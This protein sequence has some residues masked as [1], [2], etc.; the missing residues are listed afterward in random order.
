MTGFVQIIDYTTSRFDEIRA[1]GDAWSSARSS[2]S[3]GPARVTVV[4]DRDRPGHFMT[5]A[6]FDSYEAAMAN[7]QRA[8]TSDFA[9]KMGALCDAP[10][11]FTNLDVAQR[12]D[13]VA[14]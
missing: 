7:S 8:D 3:G 11:T 9:A 13:L 4:T 14:H 10:P 1:L 5:I 6:E 2:D 12:L